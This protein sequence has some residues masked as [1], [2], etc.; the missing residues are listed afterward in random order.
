[1][2]KKNVLRD[3]KAVLQQHRLGELLVLKGKITPQEL[4]NS[5]S[6]QK[7]TK[8]PLGEILIEHA[9]I[10][11]RDLILTLWKQNALRF[12]FGFLLC[13]LSVT[14]FSD[15]KAHADDLVRPGLQS[16]SLGA[17]P[18]LYGMNEKHSSNLQPFTKWTTLF[19]RFEGQIRNGTSSATLHQWEQTL[20]EVSRGSIK[21]MANQVNTKMNKVRY[22]S[23]SQNWGKSDYWETPIEFLKRGGD[24]EDY[25]ITKYVALRTL[26]VPEDRLRVAIVQDTYKNIPHAVLVVYTESGAYILDNQNPSLVS[27]EFGTRYRPIYSINRQGWWLHSAPD[28]TQMASR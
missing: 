3:F 21:D 12:C 20:S 19:N 1:M 26:G 15:K 9:L 8:R 14:G 22:I 7:E 10:S 25:A 23:D 17:Y 18:A 24:C 6:Y 27:A 5:L 16:V 4:R 13:V 2:R 28:K 11:Q